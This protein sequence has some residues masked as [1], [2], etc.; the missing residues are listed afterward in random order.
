MACDA[1]FIPDDSDTEPFACT[2]DD[3]PHIVHHD[4]IGTRAVR[5]PGGAYISKSTK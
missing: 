4:R 1:Q 2:R 5:V 3:Q